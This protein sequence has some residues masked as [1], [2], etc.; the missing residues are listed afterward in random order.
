MIWGVELYII[1]KGG[2]LMSESVSRK[3]FS[4]KFEDENKKKI[5]NEAIENG[6]GKMIKEA[7]FACATQFVQKNNKDFKEYEILVGKRGGPQ[8][9][10]PRVEKYKFMGK[11]LAT[12]TDL[13]GDDTRGTT[14]KLFLTPY[15]NFLLYKDIWSKWAEEWSTSEYEIYEKID[16]IDAPSKLI[17]DAK[18]KLG[19]D[20]SKKI[21]ETY[22]IDETI[23]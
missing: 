21:E 1:L 3:T 19:I 8:G 23:R 14:Y 12:F 13:A 2:I 10:S 18:K 16:E 7:I 9:Q 17:N 15:N 4:F 20:P 5:L 22:V 11:F 6:A